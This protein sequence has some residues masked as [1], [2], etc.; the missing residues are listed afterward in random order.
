MMERP[1]EKGHLK[2]ERD[3][4]QGGGKGGAVMKL[5]EAI[6]VPRF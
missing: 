5:K 3:C 6:H 4:K 1:R 2:Q